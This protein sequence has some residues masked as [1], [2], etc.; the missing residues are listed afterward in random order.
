MLR[1]RSLRW[2]HRRPSSTEDLWPVHDETRKLLEDCERLS[3]SRRHWACFDGYLT[4]SVPPHHQIAPFPTTIRPLRREPDVALPPKHPAWLFAMT[5]SLGGLLPLICLSS[6]RPRSIFPFLSFHPRCFARL[7][8]VLAV[9]FSPSSPFD[10]SSGNLRV[11]SF[12][13]LVRLDLLPWAK[14]RPSNISE[15][16]LVGCS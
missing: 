13:I 4:D 7:L 16:F 2:H 11:S 5:G 9:L 14:L 1:T 12:V 15:C 10:S 3:I 8:P 6:L